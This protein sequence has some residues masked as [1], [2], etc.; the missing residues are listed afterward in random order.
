MD[1]RGVRGPCLGLATKCRSALSLLLA[2]GLALAC[3][4]AGSKPLPGPVD[5]Q[6]SGLAVS[7]ELLVGIGPVRASG[8]RPETVLFVR[9][10]DGETLEDLREK[11]ELIP[12]TFVKGDYA[13]LLNAPPGRYV[14]VGA[15]YVEDVGATDVPMTARVNANLS[16]GY[17]L[18]LSD[19][20]VTHRSYLSRDMIERSLTSVEAGS[21]AFM[22]S[23][24][25][26]QPLL[27]GE[28]DELQLHFMHVVEGADVDRSG[29]FQDMTNE[30]RSHCV[31]LRSL[32]QGPEAARA[33]REQARETLRDTAWVQV[34]DGSV[35]QPEHGGFR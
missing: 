25:A 18:E 14:A 3:A 16:L 17:A 1:V 21:F 33:F 9:L 23:F 15:T 28:P 7:L 27:F 29:F 20:L 8:T 34:I 4:S 26:D 32:Q 30:G 31:T 11:S 12:S 35:A 24:A 2:S 5:P 10:E 22:G 6:S 13:Y 19:G